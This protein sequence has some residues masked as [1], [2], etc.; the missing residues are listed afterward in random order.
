MLL[1][2]IIM[3]PRGSPDHD[4]AATV[5]ILLTYFDAYLHVYNTHAAHT[6]FNALPNKTPLLVRPKY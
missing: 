4:I 6:H 3:I 5:F 2:I 1:I